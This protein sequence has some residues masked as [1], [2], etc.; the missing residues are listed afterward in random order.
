MSMSSLCRTVVMIGSLAVSSIAFAD[1]A[2]PSKVLIVVSA[3]GRDEGKTRPGFEMDEFAQAYLIFRDNG[4]DVDVASPAGGAVQA[5]K[6]NAKERFNAA[7]LAD[8]DAVAK[9]AAT[10][11]TRDIDASQYAAV[12]VV[13]GKG[14]MFDLPFDTALKNALARVYDAG[15]ILAAVCH[16]PAA[17]VDVKLAD[18]SSLVKGRRLTGFTNE[19][20]MVFGKRWAKEFKFLLEDAM[21]ERS[22]QWH[23]A[24]LMMPNLVVD[25]RLI[26]GQN[27]Y[28]TT[29]VA[30]AVVIA[31]GRTPVARALWRD[32]ATMA[33]VQRLLDGD[34]RTVREQLAKNPGN[35]HV[36]LIGMLG[37]Y[38]LQSS[39]NDDGVRNSLAIMQL[40]QPHMPEPQLALGIADA[41]Q[42]LGERVAAVATLDSLLASHPEMDEAKQLRA[43]ISTQP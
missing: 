15:G 17:L 37:Y 6:F 27:P 20:E 30:E 24:A 29:A 28:S 9:L 42:R 36:E 11:P 43:R 13:G 4:V 23:E 35:F 38:Q 26:T 22:A 7:L 19:E 32:E 31:T 3:E 34:A 5:D 39:S 40:A 10:I 25:G 16:G 33:L 1:A 12:Y 2:K 41:Q 21:R 8:A 18:G 14:A